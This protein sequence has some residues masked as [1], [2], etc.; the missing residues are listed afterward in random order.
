MRF[1][2]KTVY[3]KPENSACWEWGKVEEAKA[4]KDIS[5]LRLHQLSVLIRVYLRYVTV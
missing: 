3:F 4:R 2:K 5:H 1:L